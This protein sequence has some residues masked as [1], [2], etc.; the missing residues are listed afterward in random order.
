[1]RW[2]IFEKEFCDKCSI[3]DRVYTEEKCN[4]ICDRCIRAYEKAQ[5]NKFACPSW[6]SKKI[7]NG[8]FMGFFILE[9]CEQ[10]VKMPKI[11]HQ[12]RKKRGVI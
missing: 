9:N 8:D 12:V 2:S 3:L 1:M 11:E 7:R 5:S 4:A 6:T 10:I